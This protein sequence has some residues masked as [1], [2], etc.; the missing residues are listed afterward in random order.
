MTARPASPDARLA[1]SHVRLAGIGRESHVS[2]RE[3]HV[4]GRVFCGVGGE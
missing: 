3:S 1:P 4:S 2:G